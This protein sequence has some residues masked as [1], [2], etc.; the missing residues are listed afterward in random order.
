MAEHQGPDLNA[1]AAQRVAERHARH[2]NPFDNP[3]Y[4]QAPIRV[5]SDHLPHDVTVKAILE[6]L[7]A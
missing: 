4:A 1:R 7:D 3:I 6:A 5:P 2:D